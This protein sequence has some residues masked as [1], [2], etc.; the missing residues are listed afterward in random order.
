MTKQ[1]E[2]PPGWDEARVE[3]AYMS[4]M[5]SGHADPKP[6][7]LDLMR[8]LVESGSH[9]SVIDECFR[10]EDMVA[11]HTYVETGHKFGNVV[12]RM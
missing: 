10:M 6:A 11:A 9:D 8:D 1:S 2:F 3:R 4:V 7:D 12:V 5:S